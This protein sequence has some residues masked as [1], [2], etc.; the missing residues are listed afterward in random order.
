MGPGGRSLTA[1]VGGA[2][3]VSWR[4]GASDLSSWYRTHTLISSPD[5]LLDGA[6]VRPVVAVRRV[7]SVPKGE[8]VEG[9]HR[10]DEDDKANF[11]SFLRS[12]GGSC[13]LGKNY[14]P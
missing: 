12:F 6:V 1:H 10:D 9:D 14:N 4:I 3:L 5:G 11:H 2:S 13:F 7:R 8:G